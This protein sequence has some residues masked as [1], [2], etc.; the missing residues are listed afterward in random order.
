MKKVV[1]LVG[2]AVG[3]ARRRKDFGLG[4]EKSRTSSGDTSKSM[5][6]AVDIAEDGDLLA[7]G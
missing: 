5:D 7:V 4:K 2:S 6:T 3:S 1:R